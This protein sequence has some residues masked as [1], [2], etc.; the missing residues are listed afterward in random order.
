LFLLLCLASFGLFL[1]L[2]IN[3]GLFIQQL[4]Y[5]GVALLVLG[6]IL[7]I[8]V[9]LLVWLSPFAYVGGVLLLV[10]SYFGPIIRGARRWILIGSAQLQTSEIA[11]PLFLLAYAWLIA[12][13]PPK[14]LRNVAIHAIVFFLPFLLV[15]KQPDLGT[16]LVYA[17][18]WLAM[19][20]AGGFPIRTLV[21]LVLVGSVFTPFL[22]G[23]LHNYQQ[24]RI[25]TF[26]N[27]ALDPKG[28]GYNAVQSMIAV[29]SG[30]LIGRG[31]GRGTQSHLRFLPEYH[32]DFIFATLV[33]ELGLAGGLLLLIFYGAILLRILLPLLRGAVDH[34]M[35]FVYA[36]GLA[37]MLLTQVFIN[38]GMNMG[39]IPITGI[40]LPF[41][42]YG[43]SSL[44]SIAISFGFLWVLQRLR[45][46]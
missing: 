6:A 29:G 35:P 5:L 21:I 46:P 1:L 11:K 38:A 15:F 18:S 25:L 41:V 40:T 33:E 14:T 12:R 28:A 31:L 20:I 7:L 45:T 32:T 8:D 24:A 43:G 36:V 42:S 3:S 10:I 26:L 34:A 22:W 30:Q 27:P 17:A 44:L 37:M 39:I 13:L 19:M 2:T 23:R 4:A 9:S 16:S